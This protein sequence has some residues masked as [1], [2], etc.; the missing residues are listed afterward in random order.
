[1]AIHVSTVYPPYHDARVAQFQV[2][3]GD[4]INIPAEIFQT[5][6]RVMIS[7]FSPTD[8]L[9]WQYPVDEFV[10]AIEQGVAVVTAD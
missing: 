9:A 7:L 10:A 2:R 6:G 3:S 5:D 4:V 8:G 1:M